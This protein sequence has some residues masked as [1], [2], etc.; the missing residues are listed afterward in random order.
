MPL[1]RVKLAPVAGKGVGVVATGDLPA[2]TFIA[3]YPGRVLTAAQYDHR[4][5]RGL[6]TPAYAVEYFSPGHVLDPGGPNGTLLPA[7]RTA[8][9]PRINEPGPGQRPNVVWVWNFPARRI[10]MW[11]FRPVRAGHELTVCYGTSGDYPRS[12]CTPCAIA[13]ASATAT[14]RPAPIEPVVHVIRR[15]GEVPRPYTPTTERPYEF[16]EAGG[17]RTACTG[18][19]SSGTGGTGASRTGRS[20]STRRTARP[21]PT[22]ARRSRR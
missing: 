14:S 1:K 13:T 10:D 16:T 5:R 22:P 11:T 18:S 3:A 20:T 15:A 19:A 12:Y 7:Y 17:P 21:R 8:L 4:V 6:T 2:W 9:A